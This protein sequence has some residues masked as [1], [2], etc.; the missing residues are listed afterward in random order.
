MLIGFF[1]FRFH[2]IFLIGF[3]FFLWPNVFGVCVYLINAFFETTNCFTERLSKGRK[4][5]WAEKN[6]QNDSQNQHMCNTKLTHINSLEK[7]Y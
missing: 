3:K 7:F 4:S 5:A 2:R 1:F 6:Q